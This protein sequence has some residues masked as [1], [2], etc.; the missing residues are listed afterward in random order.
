MR[1]TIIALMLVIPLLFV[2]LVFSSVNVASLGVA[3]SANGITIS[4]KSL[5]RDETVIIDLAGG[6][7]YSLEVKVTPDN[8]ANKGYHFEV[9]DEEGAPEVE[10]SPDGKITAKS[11]GSAKVYAVSNDGGYKDSVSVLVNAS[12]PYDFAFSLSDVEL[13]EEEGE[14][15]ATIPTGVYDYS[16]DIKPA[17]FA[18]YDIAVDSSSVFAQ[19]DRAA[20]QILFPFSGEV[21]LNV[22]VPVAGGSELE[23]TINLT[24]TNDGGDI[25]I[26]GVAGGN[27]VLLDRAA[28]SASFYVEAPELPQC[29][30]EGG[31]ASF[32]IDSLGGSGYKVNVT[33]EES[34]GQSF[35]ATVSAGGKTADVQFA[36]SEF[37]FSIRSPLNLSSENGNLTACLLKGVSSQFYALPAVL[38]DDV[39]FVWTVEEGADDSVLTVSADTLNCSV[40]PVNL[41]ELVLS[42]HAERNG[43]AVSSAK[44]VV[45]DVIEKIDLV[46]INNKTD[47]DLA[48]RYTVG[49]K[50]YEEGQL[51]QNS[52]KINLLTY[53]LS[54]GGLPS[55]GVS[56]FDISVSDQSK[57]KVEISQGSAWLVPLGRGE[58]TLTF[59]WKGNSTFGANV[60]ASLT[61]NVDKD[62]VEVSTSPQLEKAAQD[63]HKIVLTADIMLGTDDGGKVKSV[64]DRRAVLQN[65]RFKS[66]Y[67]I[68]WYKNSLNS[69]E[70][71]ESDAYL[72]YAVEFKADV[73]GNG[74][75]IDAENY[76]NA[77]DGTGNP[78]FGDLYREPLYFVKC[79]NI[80]SVA[81]QDNCAFLV[82]T[83]GVTLYGV[84][85]LGCSDSSLYEHSGGK[86]S[87][88]VSLLNGVG[89]V[90]DINADVS[91][92]NCRVRNGRNVV[93]VYGGNR[94]GDK[95]FIE[96]VDQNPGCD[97]ERIE[98]RIEG[99]IL[100]QAR[101]F[102]LKIGANRAV[103]ANNA[104]GMDPYLT[105]GLGNPYTDLPKGSNNYAVDD[106]YFYSRYVLTDVTL[107]DSVLETSGLFSIGIE[108]N[109]SG[110]MMFEG[111]SHNW[112]SLTMGWETC[113]GTSFA[114]VLRLE[115]DVR[116]YDWKDLSLI[117]SSTLISSVNSGDG[118]G[119]DLR[120]QLDI[121]SIFRLVNSTDPQKY[122]DLVQNSDGKLY[123]HGGIVFYGGGRNYSVLDTSKLLQNL[124]DLTEYRINISVLKNSDDDV[125]RWQGECLPLA[126]GV[127]DFNF[128]L[129]NASSAN[130]YQKQLD[131]AADGSKYGGI[132]KLV[133]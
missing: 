5:F 17:V 8:A 42:V 53:N 65:H 92:L 76:T 2:F 111:A 97:G 63:G 22:S 46:R 45:F 33:L 128:F 6:E 27:T 43:E 75:F 80:A 23:K 32:D 115:G 52:Y 77:K 105:D 44:K 78:A 12:A 18:D 69:S 93:R 34:E 29:T 25:L 39:T 9:E 85:L 131:D 119:I 104:N 13:I 108:S 59:V 118:G 122:G 47:S 117:D 94:Q 127:N 99:C 7:E 61:V 19:V 67:N 1:K 72:T 82:R 50:K 89:T 98:V 102:L 16:M 26:N 24:T 133:Y 114:S 62:A 79:G 51:V 126:A 66:T 54:S 113:G 70:A 109:F 48:A 36:F 58:V 103:R 15:A 106:E 14:L 71:T 74:H 28:R 125:L 96:S 30:A 21:R 84:N 31:E 60:R 68:E 129:Y 64:S 49:G 38:A 73:Y 90:L 10:V 35:S 112:R 110:D 56:D 107:K 124:A 120:L 37:D 83:D 41:G 121:E 11:V 86:E 87:Y 95:Y 57:A 4:N 116:L 40:L 101:E 100:L 81:G 130:N 55:G 123:A 20:H 91:L 3:I 132:V 88:N